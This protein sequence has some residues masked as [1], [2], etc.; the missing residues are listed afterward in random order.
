MYCPI[1]FSASFLV[2]ILALQACASG[3]RR[4]VYWVNPRVDP[5]LQQHQFTLDSADCIAL[6]NRQIPEPAPEPQPQSGTITLLTPSG[7]VFGT[8]QSQPSQPEGWR[9]TGPLAGMLHAQRDQARQNYAVACI[10]NKG[11]QQRERLIHR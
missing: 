2:L 6:A 1:R 10:A 4:E 3:P 9:P 8:Y 11:W 5:A 7:P